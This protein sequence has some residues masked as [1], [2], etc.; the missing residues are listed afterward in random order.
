MLVGG[1][2]GASVG[3]GV[4]SGVG[5]GVDG[6]V[7]EKVGKLVGGRVAV[8]VTVGAVGGKVGVRVGSAVGVNVGASDGLAV[9]AF[10]G[11]FIATVEYSRKSCGLGLCSPTPVTSPSMRCV[12]S[13]SGLRRPSIVTSKPVT[14]LRIP[15]ENSVLSFSGRPPA[16]CAG[17]HV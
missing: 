11:P 14:D 5:S 9:G 12:K 13:N 8:E 2:L 6:A 3:S 16:V 17:P 4:V 10:V 15:T 7:G 1:K